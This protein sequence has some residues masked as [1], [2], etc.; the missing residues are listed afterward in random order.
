MGHLKR[1]A[2]PRTWKIRRK[3]TKFIAKPNPGTHKTRMCLPLSVVMR[4]MLGLAETLKEVKQILHSQEVLVD[5][6]R[7]KEP[8]FPV[9]FMDVLSIPKIKKD[10]RMIINNKGF[11]TLIE[12]KNPDIKPYKVLDK[13][14][15]KGG[16]T[17]LNLSSG[18]NILSKKKVACQDT[19]VL[20]LPDKKIEDHITLEKDAYIFVTR[21]GHIGDH[22]VVQSV[23]ENTVTYK[24]EKGEFEVLK[25]FLFIVGKKKPSINVE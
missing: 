16:V 7:R 4:D 2:A 18:V 19:I 3:K 23:D 24:S 8:R 20:K 1:L 11:L 21:G 6:V 12:A 10:Y 5:G 13:T 9:G 15:L 14:V 22:G 17:Q 25:K